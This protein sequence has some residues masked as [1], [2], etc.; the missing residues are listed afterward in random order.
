MSSRQTPNFSPNETP[1]TADNMSKEAA[2]WGVFSVGLTTLAVINSVEHGFKDPVSYG[3][4]SVALITAGIGLDSLRKARKL[5]R[6]TIDASIDAPPI[7][8]R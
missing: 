5:K 3:P 2:A 1:R 7:A 6:S 8:T 4:T